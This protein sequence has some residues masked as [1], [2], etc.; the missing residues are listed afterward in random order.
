MGTKT[1]E[2][3]ALDDAISSAIDIL[4][5]FEPG[6]KGGPHLTDSE[7]IEIAK[8]VLDHALADYRAR[9]RH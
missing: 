4:R 6:R 8:R 2:S 9:I 5:G 3:E 7:S 1:F